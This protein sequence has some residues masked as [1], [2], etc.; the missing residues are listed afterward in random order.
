MTNP[1][2]VRT[3]DFEH[4][5]ANISSTETISRPSISYWK[6]AWMRLKKNRVA[7]LCLIVIILYILCAIF[8]PLLSPYDYYTNDSSAMHQFPSWNHPFGT[9]DLGRDLFVRVWR[10][11]RVS[12]VIGI[13]ATILNTFV[14]VVVGGISGYVGGKLDMFIMRALD[15]LNGIPNIILS[16]LIMLMLGQ[17]LLPIIIALVIVGW[18]GTARI[19]RGQVL[20]IKELEFVAAARVMGI[21]HFSIYRRHILPN[22]T[23][24]LITS[25]T[26]AIPA[27]IFSEAFLS[28]IGLGIAPPECSL[29]LL[30]RSGSTYFK[31]YPYQLIFPA[32]A[33][34]I[35]ML[36]FSLLGD[37]LRDALDPNL[38]GYEI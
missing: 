5:G 1:D 15:V 8:F 10:G 4:V 11:A 3:E 33:I 23:G 17:G 38:R 13:V 9:D 18:V 37:G 22:I 16:L 19:V 28:Y 14:G 29:G 35:L 12:L 36:A 7:F 6:D 26:M 20:Q 30:A 24:L 31:L 2:T 27:A 21:D 34:S 32:L 25:M